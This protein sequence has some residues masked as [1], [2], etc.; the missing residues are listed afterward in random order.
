MKTNLHTHSYFSDGSESPE[1]VARLAYE[2]DVRIISLTD[3]NT[4]D[5]YNRFESACRSYGIKAIKGVEIDCVEPEINYRSELLAYFPNGGEEAIL[6]ILAANLDSRKNKV[7][8]AI[9]RLRDIFDVTDSFFNYD[10]FCEWVYEE[11]KYDLRKECSPYSEISPLYLSNKFLFRF[12]TERCNIDAGEYYDVQDDKWWKDVWATDIK[13]NTKGLYG[14]I[15]AVANAGGY[16]VLPHFGFHCRLDP[17][18]MKLNSDKFLSQLRR[19]QQNGLWGIEQHPYRYKSVA[20]AINEQVKLWADE[21][22]LHVT[23][24]SD[25]H[26]RYS[27]QYVFDAISF[28][29]ENFE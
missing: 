17:S 19:M 6:P 7:L 23:C 4:F 25:F 11:S 21:L 27:S 12:M 24:G 8:T 28:D 14:T 15:R 9:N 20:Q 10:N 16:A 5:S 13:S 1:D 18:D 29:F 3:H 22:N 2:S 26:G